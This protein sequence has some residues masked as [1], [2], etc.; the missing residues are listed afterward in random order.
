MEKHIVLGYGEIGSSLVEVLGADWVDLGEN[1]G[2]IKD[3]YEFLH[4]CIPYSD[5]FL[6]DVQQAQAAYKP[7]ITVIH[8]TVPIGTSE[9]LDAVHSPIRGVHPFL[10]DSIRTFVKFFGGPKAEVAAVPFEALGIE[11]KIAPSSRDTEAMKLWSTTQY[12]ISIL[13]MQEIHKFC[14]D[15][16]LDFDTVYT[17]GNLTYNEGY[18]EMGRPLVQRPVLEFLGYGIGGHCC[19]NNSKL[20][21]SP[22][23]EM[24]RDKQ[25]EE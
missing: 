25:G 21:D 10:A 2:D 13:L 5:H 6:F 17:E 18:V 15:N 12:G 11:T 14:E 7:W 23:A 20:L 22:F 1:S 4:V 8:S 16:G 3:S 24:L 19:V 9:K